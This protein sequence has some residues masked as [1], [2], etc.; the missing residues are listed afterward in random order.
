MTLM[1][2]LKNF[3]HGFVKGD[4]L[5]ILL[6]NRLKKPLDSFQVMKVIAKKL[7]AFHY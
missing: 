4:I 7:M 1:C 3:K 2:T 6:R 5:T